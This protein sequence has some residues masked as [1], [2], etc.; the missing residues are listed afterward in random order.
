MLESSSPTSPS[1]LFDPFLRTFRTIYA[2]LNWLSRFDFDKFMATFQNL[3]G[4]HG[5]TTPSTTSKK[6]KNNMIHIF[7]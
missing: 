1:T 4:G 6:R 7:L 3:R 5:V 2:L